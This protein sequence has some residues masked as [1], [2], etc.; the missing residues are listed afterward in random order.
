MGLQAS[1]AIL[2]QPDPENE[3]AWIER[4]IE[5]SLVQRNDRL[6]VAQQRCLVAQF[7]L[8][9]CTGSTGGESAHRRSCAL[10][11]DKRK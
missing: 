1:E 9:R 7:S 5:I 11:F 8:T 6:K 3:G 2:L 10:W 4:T